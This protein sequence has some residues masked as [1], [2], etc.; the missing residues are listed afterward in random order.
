MELET[1]MEEGAS[2]GPGSREGDALTADDSTRASLS[3]GDK[4]PY[5]QLQQQPQQGQEQLKSAAAM[6]SNA[7][8]PSSS[9]NLYLAA[10][11][12]KHYDLIIII[13]YMLFCRFGNIYNMILFG[14][15]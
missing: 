7:E 3:N 2:P 12:G 10:C 8:R 9:L 13:L 14:I 1:L 4:A 6:K 5:C 15:Y 11:T